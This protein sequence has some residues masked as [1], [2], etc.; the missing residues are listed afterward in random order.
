MNDKIVDV[1]ILLTLTSTSCYHKTGFA[2]LEN[3]APANKN[4][5]NH[6]TEEKVQI[7]VFNFMQC[8]CLLSNYIT[9]F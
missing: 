8:N 3:T 5:T 7:R 1:N 6:G 9:G 2:L 4:C